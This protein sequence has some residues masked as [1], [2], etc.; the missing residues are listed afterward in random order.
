M[1]VLLEF[2]MFPTDKG[3]S[4]SGYVSKIINM[5]D[6][7]RVSYSFTSMGTIIEVDS[8]EEALK[9]IQ[10]AYEQLEPDCNRVYSTIKID[11]RKEKTGRLKQKIASI[12]Q[13]IGKKL[14]K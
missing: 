12:E 1:S 4:V 3:E 2:A 11:I 6:E 8:L 14:N 13:K 10:K 7:S 9:I 5:I